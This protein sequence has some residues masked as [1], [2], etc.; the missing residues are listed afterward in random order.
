MAD[1]I[2]PNTVKEKLDNKKVYSG[3]DWDFVSAQ[4]SKLQTRKASE[5][6]DDTIDMP[7][8]NDSNVDETPETPEF[9]KHTIDRD[10]EGDGLPDQPDDEDEPGDDNTDDN[11][12]DDMNKES[13]MAEVVAKAKH[14]KLARLKLKKK[15]LANKN[16]QV[17]PKIVQTNR[18]LPTVTS[19][20]I[21]NFTDE[22]QL[23]AEAIE[24]AIAAG[25]DA[26]KNT[27]LAARHQ[28]RMAVAAKIEEAREQEIQK[29]ELLSKRRAFREGLVREAEA[30][31]IIK[32]ANNFAS[33]AEESTENYGFKTVS[34]LN[35]VE[36]NAFKKIAQKQGFPAE[37]VESLL[38]ISPTS[39]SVN[40]IIELISTEG[41]SKEAKVSAV[42][43]MMKTAELSDKDLNYLKNYWSNILGYNATDWVDDLFTNKYY[44]RQGEENSN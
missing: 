8:T 13:A 10:G 1:R 3:V 40:Q 44:K 26:L 11:D 7:D 24:A 21:V 31:Q 43:S 29:Q 25:D 6:D 34:E 38:D 42:K 36:R 30:Q 18:L 32:T 5:G 4:I 16:N 33:E 14:K 17:A 12:N 35:T 22:K 19:N 27:I 39:D 15:S 9:K 37:Y 41:L 2:F 28:R 20:K 23:T